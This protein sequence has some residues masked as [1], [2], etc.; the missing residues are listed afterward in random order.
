[1]QSDII[2]QMS[3]YSLDYCPLWYPTDDEHDITMIRLI[4]SDPI[5]Y[6]IN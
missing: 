1:M 5:V 3:E 2:H 4:T 6:F